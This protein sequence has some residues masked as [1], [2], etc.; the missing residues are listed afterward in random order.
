[1]SPDPKK[2]QDILNL[3]PPT[4]VT[5]VRS[6]L[7]M[8]N[9]CARFIAGYAT[10]TQPLRELTHKQQ[11]WEWTEKHITALRQL[12]HALATAPVTAYFDPNKKTELSTDASPVGLGAILAQVDPKTGNRNVIAYASRSLTATEQ[13]YS[14]TEREV[15]AAVWAC[16]RFHLYIYGKPIDIYT[17]N[18]PLVQVYGNPNSKPCPHRQMDL[19]SPIVL[20]H[21][22]LPKGRR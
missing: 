7:G 14:Q 12:K 19:T 10:I 9:Y 11:P 1:M 6:L 20:D 21:V 15:L 22:S 17:G 3:A 16:E 5:E 8:T 18:K 4:T 13:R 2:I